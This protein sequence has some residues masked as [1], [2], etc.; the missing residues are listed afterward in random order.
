MLQELAVCVCAVDPVRIN[1]QYDCITNCQYLKESTYDMYH[2]LSISHSYASQSN[3]N[4]VHITKCQQTLNIFF[5]HS[6]SK[7]FI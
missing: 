3:P 6:F 1:I 4:V 2:K 7:L 5:F